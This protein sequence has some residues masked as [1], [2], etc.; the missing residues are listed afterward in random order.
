MRPPVY[1]GSVAV[2][3]RVQFVSRLLKSGTPDAGNESR[4]YCVDS[5]NVGIHWDLAI[6]LAGGRR[7][8]RVVLLVPGQVEH[9]L[10]ARVCELTI[11]SSLQY[12]R[13]LVVVRHLGAKQVKLGLVPDLSRQ[14]RVSE[15]V[16]GQHE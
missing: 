1:S 5:V 15:H 2:R 7:A 12:R 6:R 4:P 14:A 10:Q 9:L 3:L 13:H 11:R 16:L 8:R